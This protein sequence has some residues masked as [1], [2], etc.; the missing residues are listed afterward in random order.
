M[1]RTLEQ[2]IADGVDAADAAVIAV[3]SGTQRRSRLREWGADYVVDRVEDNIVDSVRE[4][5]RGAGVDLVID[6]V[7]TTLRRRGP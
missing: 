7:G 4:Y 5:T 2:L 6:P 3:A 1:G